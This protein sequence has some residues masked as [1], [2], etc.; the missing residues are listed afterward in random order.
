LPNSTF[1]VFFFE[2]EEERC[3][4]IPTYKSINVQMQVHVRLINH[5]IKWM[6]AK[7][8]GEAFPH[9]STTNTLGHKSTIVK[10]Y[11]A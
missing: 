9:K 6:V 8:V 4:Q 1:E 10:E 11:D 3:L 5:C 7:Q 2:S